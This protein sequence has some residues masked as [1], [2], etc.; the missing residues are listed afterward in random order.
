MKYRIQSC[1]LTKFDAFRVNKD[2]VIDPEIWFK[3][4][5]NICNFKIASP[6]PYKLL[7]FF[8]IY[9]ILLKMGKH[10]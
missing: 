3:I 2:Q 5:T 9:V 10:T 7:N 1:H 6:K 8:L 4:N